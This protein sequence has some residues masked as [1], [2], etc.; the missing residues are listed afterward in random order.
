MT[1]T[2]PTATPEAAI[3]DLPKGLASAMSSWLRRRYGSGPDWRFEI[4]RLVGAG[5]GRMRVILHASRE[6]GPD[7]AI[8]SHASRWRNIGEYRALAAMAAASEDSVQPVHLDPLGRFFAIE[9]IEG[10]RLSQLLG[11]PGRE[12]WLARTGAWLAE[13]HR[14]GGRRPLIRRG[15]VRVALPRSAGEDAIGEAVRRLRQ[16]R[17]GTGGTGPS[18]FLHGDFHADNLFLR[19]GRLLGF[20]REYEVYG[21]VEHDLARFL[22]DLALRREGAAAEGA[23]WDGD[24]ETDRQAFFDGYGALEPETVASF[25][26]TEDLML[27]RHWRRGI[28]RGSQS[29]LD[30]M[31]RA[32]GLLGEAA[33]PRPGRLVRGLHGA[34]W[35]PD[36]VRPEGQVP[37]HPG[38]LTAR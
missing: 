8:K 37:L 36:A 34:D 21:P 7:L 30:G 32:R 10:P 14:A 9:W 29:L 17:Q 18:R 24:S 27:F 38:R 12:D 19:D 33:G 28:R 31:M 35:V 3:S 2:D 15:P 16:R 1:S 5:G 23:P 25:D 6:G 4:G 11:R 20:D 22:V 26:L 13:L